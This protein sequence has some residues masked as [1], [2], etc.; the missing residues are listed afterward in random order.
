MQQGDVLLQ[1]TNDGGEFEFFNDLVV[2]SGGLE[3]AV[4][5]SLFGGNE[6]DDG[7]QNTP[8]QWWGNDL[9]GDLARQ[10]RSRTAFLLQ[11][12]AAVPVNL[13][14]IEDAVRADL[15]WM[16]DTG[17]ASKLEVAARIPKRD[18]VEITVNIEAV[19]LESRFNFVENW[20]AS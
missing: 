20:K 15:V 4:Y 18:H 19:G 6:G 2:F 17:A 8:L 16:I 9:D 12:I 14:R 10:L 5:L 1:Q 3:T 13:R 7:S 11:S